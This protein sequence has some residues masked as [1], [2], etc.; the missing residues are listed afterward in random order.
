VEKKVQHRL[1]WN[2]ETLLY[3]MAIKHHIKQ[4]QTK[5]ESQDAVLIAGLSLGL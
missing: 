5:Q 4:N 1:N 2:T 3:F